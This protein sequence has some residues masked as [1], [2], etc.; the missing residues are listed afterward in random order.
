MEAEMMNRTMRR[1]L[2]G[3]VLILGTACAIDAQAQSDLTIYGRLNVGIVNYSGYGTGGPAAT[4]EGNFSSRLGFKGRE[5]LGGNLQALF[6]LETGFS[7][8]TG[9]GVIGSREAVVG[10]QGDFGKLRLGFMLTPL[11]DLH[12]IAGPGYTTNVT[13]DN[14]NGF[15]ANGYSNMF[16]GGSVGST[17]CT[18]VAGPAGNTNS[19]AFDNRYGNSIRYDSPSFGGFVVATQLALGESAGPNGCNAHAWSSKL[20]YTNNDVNV[21]LAYNLHR[22]V[23]GADL[24]DSIVMLAA[25]YK[26]GTTAY[27]AGYYQSLRYDN[28]GLNQLKQNGFGLLGRAFRGASTF[29]LAWYHGGAGRGDQTPVFSGIFTGDD[30][31]A[32]LYIIGYRY[33]LSKRTELWTQ[34]ALLRNGRNAGYDLGGSGVAGGP[35]TIGESP[36]AIAVGIK[37]DF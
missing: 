26:I 20:Q 10:L 2:I 11:D 23:R 5:A 17:A 18:Q 3:S 7:P 19:F 28:P 21:A 25:S 1:A 4:K 22:N 31:Q 36:R 35:G 8:D 34:F 9:Q 15:W 6:V 27:I 24:D 16:T 12:G 30:T 33:A 37:H 29:E 14:L 32:N 13:N